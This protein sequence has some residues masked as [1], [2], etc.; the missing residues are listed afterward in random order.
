MPELD[1]KALKEAALKATPGPWYQSGSPWF[2]TGGFVLAGSPDPHA[3]TVLAD[4]T[5][6]WEEQRSDDGLDADH[7]RDPDDDAAFI[8]LANPATILSL[9]AS[10]E[11]AEGREHR[12]CAGCGS[13]WS[14][15]DLDATGKVSCCPERKML[16]A[17]EWAAR[18]EA[19][20][21]RERRLR[22]VVAGCCD[23]LKIE[24]RANEMSANLM[25]DPARTGGWR[26]AENVA[27]SYDRHGL[28]VAGIRATL[29]AALS[30]EGA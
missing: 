18:A 9:L 28:K 21:Q 6:T 20:E 1:R 13:S 7:E 23:A 29:L 8:A 12:V 3:G 10:L 2:Q 22:E 17:K 5:D 30:E 4:L 19:A 26:G 15:A 27:R 14:R 11:E 25:R 16:T 24:A